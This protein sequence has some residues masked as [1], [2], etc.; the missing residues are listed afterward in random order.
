MKL[1]NTFDAVIVS[2]SLTEETIR[3]AQKYAPKSLVLYEEKTPVFAIDI[4]HRGGE[5]TPRGIVF[6]DKATDGTMFVSRGVSGLAEKSPAE[7]KAYLE[8]NYGLILFN[9]KKIE[10]QVTAALGSVN[11]DIATVSDSLIVIE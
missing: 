7:R 9:L 8:E 2:T 1:T 11:A 4:G 10:D 6:A 3:K 5:V